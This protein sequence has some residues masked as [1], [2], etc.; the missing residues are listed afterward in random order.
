M[1]NPT[2]GSGSTAIGDFPIRES[3]LAADGERIVR[4]VAHH[5]GAEV[6]PVARASR[7]NCPDRERFRGLLPPPVA[8]PG[9]RDPQAGRRVFTLGDCVAA[10]S[11]PP[12]RPRSCA[13]PSP[14]G[15]T[16]WSPAAP[17]P[18]KTTNAMLLAEVSKTSDR[19]VLIEDTR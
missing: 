13:R 7:P 10:G 14:T 12:T 5:V 3:A 8:L 6:H 9:L 1:L 4:L 2:G 16:F 18:G 19:V 17:R 15:A 11:W